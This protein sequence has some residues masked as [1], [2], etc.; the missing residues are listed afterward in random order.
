MTQ[1]DTMNNN[2]AIYNDRTAGTMPVWGKPAKAVTDTQKTA[3]AHKAV[4]TNI[5][6]AKESENVGFADIVDMVNPLQ[7]IPLVNIAYQKIT[8][9][10]IKPISQIIGGGVF[11]GA[12]GAGGAL[13][14]VA[15]KAETGKNI[16]EHAIAMVDTEMKEQYK[17]NGLHDDP[18]YNLN[19]A[20]AM[21]EKENAGNAIAFADLS[22][23]EYHSYETRPV[24]DGRTAGSFTQRH[25]DLTAHQPVYRREAITE[26]EL[27]AMPAR[28]E[29]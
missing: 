13:V 15:I 9:D 16:G 28:R 22:S 19:N 18:E 26:V 21:L 2:Y 4:E 23:D 14:N 12:L 24:A 25:F 3:E 5:Y 29:F 11:G 6:K 8:G 17:G 20:L 27:S 10:E 7:H 1:E